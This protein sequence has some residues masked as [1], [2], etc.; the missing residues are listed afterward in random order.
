MQ[1]VHK[2]KV[3]F[4]PF[5]K[6]LEYSDRFIPFAKDLNCFL[7]YVVTNSTWNR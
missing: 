3:Y 4:S 6:E 5:F 2:T 1:T 7:W